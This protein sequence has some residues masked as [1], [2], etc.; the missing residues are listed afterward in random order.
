MLALDCDDAGG[1]GVG[2]RDATEDTDE[3]K[4]RKMIRAELKRALDPAME[5]MKNQFKKQFNG[6]DKKVSSVLLKNDIQE[7][8]LKEMMSTQKKVIK[9][10]KSK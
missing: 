5:D 1:S 7:K 2:G 6:I 8:I 9:I 3:E 10:L 4:M